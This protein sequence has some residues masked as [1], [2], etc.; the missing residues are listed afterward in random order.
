MTDACTI[1]LIDDGSG[2]KGIDS[3]ATVG[4]L[5]KSDIL[6]S[7]LAAIKIIKSNVL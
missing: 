5:E 4:L 3:T 7:A 1:P 6:M 2:V